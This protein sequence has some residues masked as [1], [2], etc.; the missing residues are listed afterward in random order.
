MNGEPIKL[1]VAK[2]IVTMDPATPTATAIAVQG[3]RIVGIGDSEDPE[4][5]KAA[6]IDD[7]FSQHILLPGFVEAH[8]HVMSGGLWEFPYVG[9]YER[10]DPTG[11]IWK[12]C[13]DIESVVERLVEYEEQMGD[14]TQTLIAWGLDPIFLEGDRLSAS[15]LDQVSRTRPIFVFH[16]SGHLATVN[17]EM[18]LKSG[19]D[20]H[21]PTPGVV[22]D[23]DGEP[24]GELQE[25][26]AMSLALEGL[27]SIGK[28]I[29]STEA[30]W[31]FGYEARNC[32]VT[33]VADLGTTR[34]A[35]EGQLEAW[36]EVTDEKNYPVR[37]VVAFGHYDSGAS[38]TDIDALAGL[39]V[40]LRNEEE[41]AK[42]RFGIVKLILD[43]SIQG[44]T[45]RLSPPHYFDPPAGHQGNGLWLIP[46]EQM[47]K[48]VASYH[49][50]G[51]TV[52]CHCN[53]DEASE[54]FIE[55][56][57]K[58]L[59]EHP[60]DDHRHTVQHSQLTT[61]KQYK[62]M[63][64]LGMNANIFSNHIFYWGD[65]HAEITVGPHRAASMDACATAEREN[66]K[67][68]I[69][70]DAPITP[71]SQLHT[72]WCAVNRQTASGKILGPGERIGIHKALEAS[73][74]DAAHQLRLDDEIG[75]LQVGK[76]ADFT[77]LEAD[78]YEVKPDKLKEIPVWGTVVGG[79]VHQA[80]S[81]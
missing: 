40:R 34:L 37:V 32:G 46:P 61:A 5:R 80:A 1:F 59:A 68:S 6:Q 71:M 7:R 42:L 47:P 57:E 29:M 30:K 13:G 9:F 14:P 17:S 49:K 20:R 62:K 38:P 3:D 45:A 55:A 41:T 52:H 2:K 22:R 12:G 77:V 18:M 60:R 39:A 24:N 78:P 74:I 48:I 73:T 31:N 53:G 4:L 58:A 35:L 67:F 36:R 70:S 15:H 65:Q 56:V 50:A 64:S 81:D 69:H 63:A 25:P 51:L 23:G 28:A 27:S 44:F 10:V 54:V 19:I 72:I 75:S 76:L 33:T 43:G 66:V 8:A 11:R 26:A 79:V 16:A 21:S